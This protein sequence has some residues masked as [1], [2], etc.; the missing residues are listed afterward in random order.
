VIARTPTAVLAAVLMLSAA[1]CGPPVLDQTQ[2]LSLIPGDTKSADLAA[3]D[4]PQ[5]ITV[6]YDSSATTV[7]VYVF[8]SSDAPDL[9][10]TLPVDKALAKES[11]KSGT[12][13][14]DVPAKTATRVVV[15]GAEKS[16]EVTL[17]LTNKK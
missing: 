9:G 2:K 8:K 17:H 4:K 16:T 3:V 14:V 10:K 11:G 5:K 15:T 6:K 1:G 12:L 7:N 13:T